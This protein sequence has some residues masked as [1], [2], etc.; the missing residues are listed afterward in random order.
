MVKIRKTS[1]DRPPRRQR[2]DRVHDENNVPQVGA[3]IPPSDFK[4]LLLAPHPIVDDWEI[5]RPRDFGRD[6]DL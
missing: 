6:I 4:K 5:E 2:P 3:L 1:S